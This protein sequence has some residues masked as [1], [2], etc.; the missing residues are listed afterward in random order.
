M[1]GQRLS[2]CHR[3]RYRK[4]ENP[5]RPT[6]ISV[7]C[8]LAQ[9]QCNADANTFVRYNCAFCVRRWT[10]A[11][12]RSFRNCDGRAFDADLMLENDY[13]FLSHPYHDGF[14][15]CAVFADVARD[16]SL[17]HIACSTIDIDARVSSHWIYFQKMLD[18]VGYPRH[19]RQRCIFVEL[20]AATHDPDDT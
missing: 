2:P 4:I 20:I 1:S 18:R 9:S 10:G 5:M 12:V 6:I 17:T 14:L 15:R 8:S 3:H 7:I 19:C 13:Y 11:L 16:A